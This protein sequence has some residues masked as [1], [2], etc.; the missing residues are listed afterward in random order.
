MLKAPNKMPQSC[1]LFD[2]LLCFLFIC[3]PS[4]I[5]QLSVDSRVIG[6]FKRKN[7]M[8]CFLPAGNK[9]K[10]DKNVE[11]YR[12]FRQRN[13]VT[14]EFLSGTLGFHQNESQN[15]FFLKF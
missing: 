5:S 9:N 8:S 14:L 4:Y 11:S 10:R 2:N 1:K 13:V 7:S 15:L 6:T 12:N 3:D